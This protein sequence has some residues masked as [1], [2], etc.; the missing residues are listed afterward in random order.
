MSVSRPVSVCPCVSA[1]R[2]I[3]QFNLFT[4]WTYATQFCFVR[5]F[6]RFNFVAVVYVRSEQ[7][8]C[9]L[10]VQMHVEKLSAHAFDCSSF[11]SAFNLCL[12]S[13][14]AE[15]LIAFYLIWIATISRIKFNA[16]QTHT[17]TGSLSITGIP[18]SSR[19]ERWSL[20]ALSPTPNMRQLKIELINING[21]INVLTSTHCV[22]TGK[23]VS[24]RTATNDASLTV[25]RERMCHSARWRQKP[26][27]HTCTKCKSRYN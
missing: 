20:S 2:E 10:P 5:F 13:P 9:R 4:I 17:H 12:S 24:R 15:H 25:S 6:L 22:G 23:S 18:S 7:L 3:F 16:T 26:T 1:F 8:V 27:L 14:A 11:L 19:S 21:Q